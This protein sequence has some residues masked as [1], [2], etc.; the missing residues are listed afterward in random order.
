M[1]LRN[2]QVFF[3]IAGKKRICSFFPARH[4]RNLPT[5]KIKLVGFPASCKV[6]SQQAEERRFSTSYLKMGVAKGL[7]STLPWGG[8]GGGVKLNFSLIFPTE[9]CFKSLKASSIPRRTLQKQQISQPAHRNTYY[10]GSQQDSSG[11]QIRW[12]PLQLYGN[13]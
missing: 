10:F 12:V 13:F 9:L 7:Q 4:T 11:E 5:R 8:G 3:N 6:S 1:L 2:F